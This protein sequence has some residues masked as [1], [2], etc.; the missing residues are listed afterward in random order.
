M[1]DANPW[2]THVAVA[3]PTPPAAA[4]P[5]SRVIGEELWYPPW[6]G[7][8]AGI[9]VTERTALEL[10][11]LLAALTVLATDTAV[12]PLNVYQRRPDGGRV[13]R[14][15]HPVEE[16]LALN[17]DGEG[18]STAVTW[19]SAWMGHALTHGNGYAEVQRT[20]RGATYGLHLLDP[21]TT[22]AVRVDGK[23]KYRI[24]ANKYL[25]P[26]NVLHL[27]GLGYDGISGYSYVR[28]LRRAIGV[29]IAEETY[30]ADYFANGSEPGGVIESPIAMKPESIRNLR[31]GWEGRHGGPGQRHRVAVLEQGAKWNATAT[32]PEKAQLIESRKYQLLEVI[33]AWRVPP[34]KA[35]DLSQA[36]LSNIE[37]SNLDYLMTALMYWLVAIEQ[38]CTLKLFTPA[39]RR[40]G[41]YVEHNVNALLRGDIV[42]RFNAYHAALA[43]GW[44]SRDEVRARENLNPIGEETG[45][46][47][48]LVQLNQTTLEL[49]GEETETTE[50]MAS[51]PVV[52][53]TG[54]P[55][56]PAV[57]DE[58][59]PDATAL[60]EVDVQQTALNGAQITSLVEMIQSV[61]DGKLPPES[62]KAMIQAS[63]P[64]LSQDIIN[65]MVN[66]AAEFTPEP[67]PVSAN[68]NGQVKE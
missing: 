24:D 58:P 6:A 21:E 52:D 60:A 44:M 54:E 45:G 17:P 10:P 46:T 9:P 48:Y 25:A 56:E 19:R 63:F 40:T 5:E 68:G 16:R 2:E 50:S 53:L 59:A 11:A 64:M 22:R 30:T 35:G 37:A 33:R 49:I 61:A 67:A 51:A 26:A 38:Q 39:E 4:P 41:L 29:G 66:P 62:A 14:Y 65:A 31:Q 7:G 8:T 18:E 1:T 32:D 34:N 55:D 12:L 57:D 3:T 47:K 28:L 27:A 13:H 15:D 36:H 23:L 20:G 43:D 42:S